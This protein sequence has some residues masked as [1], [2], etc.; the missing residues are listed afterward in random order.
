[1]SQSVLKV[2]LF[3]LSVGMLVHGIIASICWNGGGNPG[4]LLAAQLID[5]A[6]LAVWGLSVGVVVASQSTGIASVYHAGL[7]L[8]LYTAAYAIT[9]VYYLCRCVNNVDQLPAFIQRKRMDFLIITLVI[10]G[11]SFALLLIAINVLLMYAARF[12][13]ATRRGILLS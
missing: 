13:G 4:S 5:N 1:M 12:A 11:I 3:L 2:C 10:S 9:V 6:L 8:L 7:F